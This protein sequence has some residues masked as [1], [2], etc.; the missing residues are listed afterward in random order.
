[1]SSR[2]R[3]PVR[4]AENARPSGALYDARMRVRYLRKQERLRRQLRGQLQRGQYAHAERTLMSLDVTDDVVP[5]LRA[6]ADRLARVAER[7]R[8]LAYG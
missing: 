8:D 7:F 2:D 1:M 6:H 3:G 4:T 5:I